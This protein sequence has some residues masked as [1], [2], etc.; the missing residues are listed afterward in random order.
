MLLYPKKIKYKKNHK[1]KKLYNLNNKSNKL[2][3]GTFG[4]KTLDYCILT[5][6]Q[7]E[8]GRFLL[9]KTLK[10]NGKVWQRCYPHSSFT[11]KPT[12]IR[13]GKGKG[14]HNYWGCYLKPGAIIYEIDGLNKKKSFKLL[15][16]LNY[17]MPFKS[18]LIC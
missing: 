2:I 11:K 12:E 10:K 13:M 8:A 18:K 5:N 15:K 7:L 6:I 17:K 1:L 3:F 4:I 16:V 14:K 9:K